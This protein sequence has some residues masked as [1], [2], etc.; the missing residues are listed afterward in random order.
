MTKV[1]SL[2]VPYW[3]ARSGLHSPQYQSWCLKSLLLLQ[4]QEQLENDEIVERL[5]SVRKYA[6]ATNGSAPFP[7]PPQQP[8]PL[9][10][11]YAYPL[12]SWVDETDEIRLS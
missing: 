12:D 7:I 4:V 2:A 3:Q 5:K 6:K 10:P 1:L 9:S 8:P 11:D